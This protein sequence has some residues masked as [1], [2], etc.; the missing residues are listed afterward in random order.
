MCQAT[1]VLLNW[2][3]VKEK[4]RTVDSQSIWGYTKDKTDG[5]RCGMT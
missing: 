5:M 4:E 3:T 1:N 2:G